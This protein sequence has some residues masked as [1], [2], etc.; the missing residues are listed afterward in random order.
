MNYNFDVSIIVSVLHPDPVYLRDVILSAKR[1]VEKSHQKVE[2]LLGND[3]SPADEWHI[4]DECAAL[5][6]ELVKL[7]HFPL[8]RGIGRTR[9]NLIKK[10]SGRYVMPFD[11]DDILLPFDLDGEIAFLDQHREYGASYAQK[12]LFNENGLTGMN[13]GAPLSDFQ[14]YFTPKVNI[15]AML[16]RRELVDLCHGFRQIPGS[17]IN[18]DVYLMYR[19]I[20]E[21]K[22]YFS[23]E[24]R[25]LYRIHNKSVCHVYG[26]EQDDF[27]YMARAMAE[28]DIDLF[29]QWLARKVPVVPPERRRISAAIAG[30]A[31]FLYQKNQDFA[32]WI[33][34]S[35]VDNFPD[36]YG[37]W[38][39]F[40]YFGFHCWNL[41][42]AL[43]HL[44]TALQ[45]FPGDVSR[46]LP[47]L[48][49][50]NILSQRNFAIPPEFAELHDRAYRKWFE[51][52]ETVRLYV[53][54]A[55]KV[56]RPSYSFVMPKIQF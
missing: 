38:E 28:R 9:T 14:S 44:R 51:I 5:A 30:A 48:F 56:S 53:P 11:G 36:D 29:R 50:L 13:H 52:P 23:R 16:I 45:H 21:S 12:Y 20:R 17:H 49:N 47:L 40:L 55:V 39:H 22:L 35:A 41:P 2:L 10:S 3:G 25:S 4:F 37:A 26:G 7:F 8:N 18:E 24:G 32:L 34:Q 15:N 27:R 1:L 42:E 31:L 33:L 46:Q 19:M 54:E 6:P 43:D